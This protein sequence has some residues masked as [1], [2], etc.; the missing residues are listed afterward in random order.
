MEV[1]NNVHISNHNQHGYPI[2]LVNSN[3]LLDTQVYEVGMPDGIDG[4]YPFSITTESG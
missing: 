1:I 3:S 4:Y 2:V